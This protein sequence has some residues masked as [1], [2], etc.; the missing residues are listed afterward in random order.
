MAALV[1]AASACT[2]SEVTAPP[3]TVGERPMRPVVLPEVAPPSSTT[4]TIEAPPPPTEDVDPLTFYVS[5]TEGDD[6]NDGQTPDTPWA[7]LQGALDRVE[8][9][10]TIHLMTGVY[11]DLAEPGN[12][13]YTVD[14]GGRSDAWVR[15]TAAPGH[16]PVLAPFDGNGI[17]VRAD[18]VEVSNLAVEGRDFSI[19]NAY[20]WGI[21]VRESHHVRIAGN[22]ISAMAVGGIGSVEASN[23]DVFY[24]EV[25]D[26]SFWGAEQGSGISLWR[27]TDHGQPSR[28]DGYHDRIVGNRVYRN[29]NKVFSRWHEDRQTIT[30]GNGIIIDTSTPTGYTGRTLV[31]NNVVFDNGGRAILVL[32]ASRVDIVHN[33]TYFNGRTAILEGGPVEVAASRAGQVRVFNN[34]IWSRAGVPGVTA[35]ES[36]GIEMGGNVLVSAD[37]Q[38]GQTTDLDLTVEGDP[39]LVAP[40]IDPATADFR[41]EADSAARGRAIATD[42]RLDIDADGLWRPDEGATAGAYEWREG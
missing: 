23:L 40:A 11:D 6:G 41:P 37:R 34:L 3:T 28:S 39:G 29:E 5:P 30:D 22:R 20:G 19:D 26:N 38:V 4:S 31:A 17:V 35:H 33:T 42:P 1:L 16:Q 24:N 9:G 15:I 7:S 12:A 8:A 2:G 36:T 27:S 25:F 18:F 14:R 13:H 21:L 10:Q 32:D